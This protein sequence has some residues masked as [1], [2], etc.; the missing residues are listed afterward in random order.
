MGLIPILLGSCSKS[1]GK[2]GEMK[3]GEKNEVQKLSEEL[4]AFESLMKFYQIPYMDGSV[5]Q[6]NPVQ[7]AG[8][9][10][11]SMELWNFE[12]VSEKDL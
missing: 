8:I 7:E 4:M 5:E 11:A 10:S 9:G 1:E 6:L 12:D 2:S 3:L